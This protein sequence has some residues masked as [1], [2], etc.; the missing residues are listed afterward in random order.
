MYRRRVLYFHNV[1]TKLYNTML[2]CYHKLTNKNSNIWKINE[3]NSSFGK[4][5]NKQ[6]CVLSLMWAR[7]MLPVVCML[8][9]FRIWIHQFSLTWD[10]NRA[11]SKWMRKR[12][13]RA[14]CS[15]SRQEKSREHPFCRKKK[16]ARE[17][18]VI[19]WIWSE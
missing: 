2:A 6:T 15:T 13:T 19:V 16:I 14:Q 3:N 1:L 7:R 18:L 4:K 11:A 12:P 9:F 17:I 5:K 8:V 10:Y